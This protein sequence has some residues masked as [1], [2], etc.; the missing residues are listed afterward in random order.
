[1]TA[2]DI[3]R[4]VY[5]RS[6]APVGSVQRVRDTP[7]QFVLSYDDGPDPRYTPDILKV[8]DEFN[9]TATFFVLLS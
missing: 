4:Q 3:A 7:G 9:A 2:R 5:R 6:T 1:M 8:L